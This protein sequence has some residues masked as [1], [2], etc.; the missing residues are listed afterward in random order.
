MLFLLI[1]IKLNVRHY[2]SL[3][4]VRGQFRRL[5]IDFVS[6]TV[7]PMLGLAFVRYA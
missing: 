2:R 4:V 1:G 3:D 6:A 7:L 5:N